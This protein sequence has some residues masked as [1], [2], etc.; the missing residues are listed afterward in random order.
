MNLPA[1]AVEAEALALARQRIAEYRDGFHPAAGRALLRNQMREFADATPFNLSTLKA[2]ARA[3]W[4]DAHLTL[5][6]M[7]AEHLARDGKLPPQLADYVIDQWNP[8]LAPRPRGQS[9]AKNILRDICFVA[10]V[11]EVSQRFDLRPTRNRASRAPARR[12][13]ACAIVAEAARLELTGSAKASARAI[14]QI[15]QRLAPWVFRQ[16]QRLLEA[17]GRT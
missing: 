15:W 11:S 4:E 7:V 9:K 16:E 5:R 17:I 12:P 6:E 1:T 8:A 2:Y 13:S 10:V 3:G 14:E